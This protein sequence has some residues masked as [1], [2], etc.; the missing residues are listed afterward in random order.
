MEISIRGYKVCGSK[1][2]KISNEYMG[3][4][5]GQKTTLVLNKYYLISIRDHSDSW[6]Y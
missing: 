6:I 1:G 2:R 4:P 3:F 5:D